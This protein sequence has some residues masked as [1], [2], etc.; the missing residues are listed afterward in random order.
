MAFKLRSGNNT[1]FKMMGSSNP[2]P[3]KHVDMTQPANHKHSNEAVADS[4]KASNA[5]AK[6]MATQAMKEDDA[7]TKIENF[8]NFALEQSNPLTNFYEGQKKLTN[9]ADYT[10]VTEAVT[11]D[12]NYNKKRFGEHEGYE[13]DHWVENVAE[14]LDPT[15]YLSHDDLARA[16]AGGSTGEKIVEGVG[17]VPIPFSSAPKGVINLAKGAWNTLKGPL[18]GA[19]V[20]G[21]ETLGKIDAVQDIWDDN[22]KT[23]K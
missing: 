16:R 14:I 15:G 8:K 10:G 3:F 22:I 9:I 4:K 20:K 17:I 21:M 1:T 11:G 23:K 19:A 7:S 2:A 6:E 5:I 12:K 13:G 18:T